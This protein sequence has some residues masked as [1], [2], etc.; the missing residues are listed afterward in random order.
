MRL[1]A[2]I[3]APHWLLDIWALTKVCLA[4]RV[5]LQA[6]LA[7]RGKRHPLPVWGRGA[8]QPDEDGSLGG[9]PSDSSDFRLPCRCTG[10][11]L[12]LYEDLVPAGVPKHLECLGLSNA[13]TVC[14]AGREW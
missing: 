6:T 9:N 14:A 4:Y 8:G 1:F 3:R 5:Y 13:I 11:W 10:W 12:F 2:Y 7:G